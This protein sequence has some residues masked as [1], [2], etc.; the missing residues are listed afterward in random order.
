MHEIQRFSNSIN[1]LLF[2]GFIYRML[3]LI[4]FMS[5]LLINNLS[6]AADPN[7][8]ESSLT[9]ELASCP[10]NHKMYYI[11]ANPPISTTSKPVSSQALNWTAGNTNR[12]FTFSETSGNKAFIIDFPMLLDLNTSYGGTPPFYGSIKDAT[13][14]ALNLVHNS[15]AAKTN[16]T[17][18][19]S[20]NRS[21]SKVG[22]KIQDLDSTGNSGQVSYIEQVDVSAN[23]GLL[24]FNSNFHTRNTAGNIVTARSGVNCGSGGCTIDT[25]WNYNLPNSTLNLKHNN[26]FT[27]NNSPHAIGYS[28]FY[29]CLAPPKL[30]VKKELTGSRINDNNAKRDQFEI[31]TKAGT[32]ELNK[33]T[34]QG[35]GQNLTNNISPVITLKESTSYIISERVMNAATPGNIDDYNTS[36]ICTNTSTDSKSTMPVGNGSSISL[37]NLNYGDEVTCTITNNPRSYIFS[38]TVFDDNG[39]IPIAQANATNDNITSASSAYTNRPNYFNGVF[40]APQEIGIS[41]STIRLVNCANTATTYAT[42]SV[43]TGTTIGQYQFSVPIST[44]G[45]NSSICLLEERSGTTYPIRTNSDIRTI[46][47]ASNIYNYPDNNFGRVVAANA[48]LVLRKFQYINDCPSNLTYSSINTTL[49]P[50]TGFST[51]AIEESIIPGKCIA[52]KITATNRANIAINDFIMRDTLQ[53]KGVNNSKV[54]SVLADP[55][56]ISTD[57]ADIYTKGQNGTLVTKTFTLEKRSERSFYFN[58]KYGTTIDP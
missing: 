30:I 52:Y 51:N 26:S 45:G 49:D 29:F 57:F 17:L 1:P 9:S 15:P 23:Q 4:A 6:F 37:S 46:A 10:V 42:Q 14:S 21:V 34:T 33:F 58:T 47:F 54:T 12:T 41:G 50:R 13:T 20:I 40:N 18:N 55:P 28:D 35:E 32:T 11:G 31:S 2:S 25:A 43:G 48:A 27:Q 38:G 36:Y 39:G 5:L 22:Y 44:F 24:T 8:F 3:T 53:Q 16:H 19:V 7:L 56:R